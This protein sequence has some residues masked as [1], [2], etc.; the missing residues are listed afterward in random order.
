MPV[1]QADRLFAVGAAKDI[2]A[3]PD[4]VPSE[5]V[6]VSPCRGVPE[7]AGRKVFDGGEGGSGVPLRYTLAAFELHC[8]VMTYGFASP[9]PE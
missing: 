6:S 1:N 2:G 7:M 3:V 5:A 4:Q 8:A 9:I